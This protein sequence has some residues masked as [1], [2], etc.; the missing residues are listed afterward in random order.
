MSRDDFIWELFADE[1]V[2]GVVVHFCSLSDPGPLGTYGTLG[3]IFHC[4]CGY[5]DPPSIEVPNV[6]QRIK[7]PP[8]R[9]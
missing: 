1:D 8:E 6:P 7:D 5:E 9:L 4:G 2:Q 3:H